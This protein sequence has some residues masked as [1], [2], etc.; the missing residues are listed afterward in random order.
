MTAKLQ[1]GFRGVNEGD[2]PK[3]LPPGTLLRAENVQM[4][5]SHRLVKRR[6]TTGLVKTA[7]TGSNPATGKRLLTN[8]TDTAITDGDTVWTYVEPLAKWNPIDRIPSWGATKRG[9]ID[10]TRSVTSVDTGIS[11]DM[12][13]VLYS[14]ATGGIYVQVDDLST[15]APILTPQLVYNSV[16]KY[17]RVLINGTTALL[18][19]SGPAVIKCYQLNLTTFALDAGTTLE[20]DSTAAAAPFDATLGTPTA[21][22][23][24]LY[25]AYEL[26][27]GTDRL[28]IASFTASTLA[29]IT[30]VVPVS[31]DFTQFLTAVCVAF[32][33]SAQKVTVAYSA[34]TAT[35]G[36]RAVSYTTALGSVVGPVTIDAIPSYSVFVA[37]DDATNVLVGWGRADSVGGS[38]QI[39]AERVTT[40][41]YSVAALAQ[42]TTSR[43]VSFHLRN[44]SKPWKSTLGR[45]Y[46]SALAFPHDFYNALSLGLFRTALP[47]SVLVE[48]E[49]ASSLTGNQDATHPH[50][51][52][53][54]SQT[55]WHASTD[56]SFFTPLTQQRASADSSGVMWLVSP[57]RNRDPLSLTDALPL[58]WSLFRLSVGEGDQFRSTPLGAGSLVAGAAPVWLDGA[59]TMPYGFVHAPQ[60]ISITEAGGGQPIAN[61]NYSYVATYAWRDA[62]GV[63]HRSIPSPPRAASVANSGTST[64]TIATTSVSPKLRTLTA[65]TSANPVLVELWRTT[66]GATGSHYKLTLEPLYQV[67]VN[68]ARAGTIAV[69]DTKADAD[70][71][72]GIFGLIP[73]NT[74][75][76][77]YTD[78]GELDNV[79][80]PSFVTVTTHRGRLVGLGPDLRTVWLSKDSTLDATLAPGFNEALTLAFA[81]DKTALASLD[82]VLVVFGQDNIDV[83]QGDGPDD[84]GD[85]N[86]WQIQPVQTD[87]GCVNPRSVV[88]F[89]MGVMFESRKGIEVIDRGLGI[90]W[91]GVTIDDTLSTYPYITSAVLVA[92]QHEV[93]FTCD[94][95]ESLGAILAY[96]YL[97]KVWFTRIYTDASDT[98]AAS[99]R[100]ADAAMIDGVYTLLTVGGQVYRESA[101]SSLDGGDT[102]VETD[103]LLAPISAQPG[104]AGW[105]NDN[106]SWQ[107]VKDLT[108]MGT[109][110]ADHD[111]E[112]SFARD[113]ANTFEQT[114]T[115]VANSDVTTPGPLEKARVTVAVQ[116]CQAIQIRIRDLEPTG[117]VAISNSSAGPILESLALRIGAIDG[118]AKTT[119]GQQ[120]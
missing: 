71:G 111:L 57:Y 75:Q 36:T 6:G 51:A 114:H 120:G 42:V 112:V 1:I 66:V 107:R 19:F 72:G 40:A 34:T 113:Y 20:T 101:T 91:I 84:R 2:D 79:Q 90:S 30:S 47:S 4:D 73:L 63:L 94:D 92:E 54:E 78:V 17:P 62:N 80:P 110:T 76:Q 41:L 11:G 85:Q 99:V 23:P 50:V 15:G 52:T 55:S 116:K 53:L 81:H 86:T 27:T 60:I 38:P 7:L 117:N 67:G 28:K 21:G 58:G 26:D 119:A 16:G 8:G 109:S 89:P 24:T 65:S 5:K 96:D 105:S 12:L 9:L 29:A 10:S 18:L 74:Q 37:E 48:I 49:T 95:G 22:V 108:L 13:V 82:T 46:M 44:T 39:A 83:V 98:D 64:I 93:R 35:N 97:E 31:G 32:G 3:D 104:R 25:I 103:I 100:F 14:T 115:F 118:P 88:T 70:I 45:W 106:L 33:V 56:G 77:L 68:D 61:G 102:Y 69:T 43:R 59:S 87:V